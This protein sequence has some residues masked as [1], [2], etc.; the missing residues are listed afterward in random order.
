[1]G[2]STFLRKAHKQQRPRG[3]F[4]MFWTLRRSPWPRW[5]WSSGHPRKHPGLLCWWREGGF[6]AKLLELCMIHLILILCSNNE[7]GC[8]CGGRVSVF[9]GGFCV[10]GQP[11]VDHW[12]ASFSHQV[13]LNQMIRWWRKCRKKLLKMKSKGFY[14]PWKSLDSRRGR[15][16]SEPTQGW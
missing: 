8:P 3:A 13:V 10:S 4:G 1:M 5:P 6:G 12:T 7:P 2:W 16:P 11:L 15:L 14:W 9:N